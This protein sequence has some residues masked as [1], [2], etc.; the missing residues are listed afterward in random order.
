VLFRLA[1]HTLHSRSTPEAFPGL[2]RTADLV[3]QH[4]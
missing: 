1:V 4:L 3:R 2:A